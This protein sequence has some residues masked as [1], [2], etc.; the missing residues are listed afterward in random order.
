MNLTRRTFLKGSLA[1]A[2]LVVAPS[3]LFLA[4]SAFA[5]GSIDFLLR[6]RNGASLVAFNDALPANFKLI[7]KPEDTWLE[8]P[9]VN[10]D[11]IN[12]LTFKRAVLDGNGNVITPAVK[13]SA[14]HFNLRVTPAWAG[15][16]GITI[17]EGDEP[18]YSDARLNKSKLK[19]WMKKEG[20]YRLDASAEHPRSGR[21][22]MDWFRFTSGPRWMDITIATPFFQRRVWM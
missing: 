13:S 7:H 20:I 19:R 17:D 5:A 9:G 8:L 6:A 21:S 10:L 12:G 14:V 11:Q 4:E 16:A 1:T 2:A 22:D 18:D 15:Y 3:F